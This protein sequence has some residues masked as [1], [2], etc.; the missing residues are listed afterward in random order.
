MLLEIAI[1]VLLGT[2]LGL[3]YQAFFLI[4]A[5]LT[6]VAIAIAVGAFT[7]AGIGWIILETFIVAASLQSGYLVG[8]A[9]SFLT[10]LHAQGERHYWR[11]TP[12]L[13]NHCASLS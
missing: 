6:G 12:R 7:G 1:A 5:S 13:H 11:T 2:A 3:K 9:V 4:P 10:S 8:A